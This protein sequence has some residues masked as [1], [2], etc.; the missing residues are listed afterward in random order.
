MTLPISYGTI[1]VKFPKG[2]LAD[3]QKRYTELAPNFIAKEYQ[4]AFLLSQVWYLKRSIDPDSQG[5][6]PLSYKKLKFYLG[7]HAC[8]ML[9]FLVDQGFLD[10][11]RNKG[12][13]KSY[14]ADAGD[15]SFCIHY[16]Y[17][18]SYH[19]RKLEKYE[20]KNGPLV[21]KI[22]NK[23]KE[24]LDSYMLPGN[25]FLWMLVNA[26][27]HVKVDLDLGESILKGL[28]VSGEMDWETL[29]REMDK[30]QD[31]QNG[32]Y[33]I[34]RDRFGRVHSVF[35][36]LSK[37]LREAVFTING[38]PA[39]EIDIKSAQPA[40]LYLI[41]KEEIGKEVDPLVQEA[42]SEELAVYRKALEGDIYEFLR[43]KIN[44]KFGLAWDRNKTKLRFIAFLY[45]MK[46]HG[47]KKVRSAIEEHFPAILS[48]LDLLKTK[49]E[50]VTRKHSWLAQELQRRES[51]LVIDTVVPRIMILGKGY[52]TVHDAIYV[53]LSIQKRTLE[54]FNLFIL[55][56][57]IPTIASSKGLIQIQENGI[58][59][60]V[61]TIDKP[62]LPV[63][64]TEVPPEFLVLDF[65]FLS[66]PI[67]THPN[68]IM[69]HKPVIY[70]NDKN[71]RCWSFKPPWCFRRP[72]NLSYKGRGDTI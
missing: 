48:I 45:S 66:K 46:R 51:T 39:V 6:V 57:E 50:L 5:R 69:S 43:E 64:L 8:K 37:K 40:L 26:M 55:K 58:G 22:R 24:K 28:Q 49:N 2:M 16:G 33:H 19:G 12:G 35:T 62:K 71:H 20:I 15:A 9:A 67:P 54:L 42:L 13:R 25:E 60:L 4:W 23:K 38:E 34:S 21:I 41:L 27:R 70:Q 56:N 61:S 7:C 72:E 31:I 53:P 52:F 65:S 3:V 47:D 68:T 44:Q 17:A 14:W 11:K 1:T 10:A 63:V 59:L 32:D 18:L 29:E 36:N 30:L